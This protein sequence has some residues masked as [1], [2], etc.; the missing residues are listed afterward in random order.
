MMIMIHVFSGLD[1][2]PGLD[3]Q[4]A[5]LSAERSLPVIC[6]KRGV[7]ARALRLMNET[8]PE[9]GKNTW[10]FEFNTLS[11]DKPVKVAVDE[12]GAVHEI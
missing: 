4:Q 6:S 11:M 12:T 9:V 2:R 5:L 8:A 3:S 10:R 1:E 7:S